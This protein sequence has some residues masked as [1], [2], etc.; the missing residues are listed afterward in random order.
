MIWGSEY[1]VWSQRSGCPG[2]GPCQHHISG[3]FQDFPG[4]P[5]FQA[6]V[7]NLQVACLSRALPGGGLVCEVQGLLA[8]A[9]LQSLCFIKCGF[10]RKGW[11][12]G[13]NP[14][15]CTQHSVALLPA[16]KVR[17][18]RKGLFLFLFLGANLTFG[19]MKW[20]DLS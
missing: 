3:G 1:Q 5:V 20:P 13:S 12:Q 9:L 6:L 10:L 17:A 4:L 14:D 15:P 2:S 19:L 11:S 16:I 8:Q 7:L 18:E